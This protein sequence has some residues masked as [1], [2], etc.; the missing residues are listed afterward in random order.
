MFD[1]KIKFIGKPPDDQE[2]YLAQLYKLVDE[3]AEGDPGEK[4]EP[5]ESEEA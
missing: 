2:A 5:T 4:E 1:P 3:A